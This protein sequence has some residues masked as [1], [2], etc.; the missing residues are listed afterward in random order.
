[1]TY[2]TYNGLDLTVQ[3]RTAGPC[4]VRSSPLY[5]I[6]VIM[7]ILI[8]GGYW[9][10]PMHHGSL[11]HGTLPRR[12]TDRQTHTTMNITFPQLRWWAVKWP[13]KETG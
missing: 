13:Q 8:T 10:D 9:G 12:Q 1:M 2:I 4:T 11:S 5:V 7:T 6:Y 3:L